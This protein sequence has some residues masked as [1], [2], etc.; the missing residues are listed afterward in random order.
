MALAAANHSSVN[1][2][3]ETR[4]KREPDDKNQSLSSA[5]KHWFASQIGKRNRRNFAKV[6]RQGAFSKLVMR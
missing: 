3:R 4:F 6:P 1:P 2:R 5:F